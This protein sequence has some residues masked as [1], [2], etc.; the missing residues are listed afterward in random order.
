[1]RIR[2]SEGCTNSAKSLS[3]ELAIAGNLICSETASEKAVELITQT[4]VIV[5]REQTP[6]LVSVFRLVVRPLY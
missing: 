1:M 6:T 5:R 4:D 3:H 2:P